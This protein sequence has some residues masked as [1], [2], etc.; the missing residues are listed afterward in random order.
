VSLALPWTTGSPRHGRGSRRSGNRPIWAHR[1]GSRATHQ[2]VDPRH[3]PG[4]GH[5]QSGGARPAGSPGPD[6]G[7]ATA[8][9]AF[10]SLDFR[11]V[12]PGGPGPV[13]EGFEVDPGKGDG[14]EL[15]VGGAVALFEVVQ[16]VEHAPFQGAGS[17]GFFRGE[18][19]QCQLL[20][21]SCPWP[22]SSLGE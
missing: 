22:M 10:Q 8:I 1:I 16:V 15:E 2:L 18:P 19:R 4:Q 14:H 5:L 20:M 21:Q 12:G 7:L 3:G 11:G 17:F 6:V 13:V 9:E